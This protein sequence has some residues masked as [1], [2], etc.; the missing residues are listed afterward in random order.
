MQQPKTENDWQTVIIKQLLYIMKEVADSNNI[1]QSIFIILFL[2]YETPEAQPLGMTYEFLLGMTSGIFSHW[3][4]TCPV[5]FE[6]PG[7]FVLSQPSA[8]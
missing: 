1:I 2:C 3:P 4:S 8:V 6:D 5:H 7:H